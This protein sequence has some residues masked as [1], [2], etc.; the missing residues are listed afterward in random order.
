MNKAKIADTNFFNKIKKY[1]QLVVEFSKIFF[2]N[3]GFRLF[4]ISYL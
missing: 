1:D 2:L 3:S 4:R